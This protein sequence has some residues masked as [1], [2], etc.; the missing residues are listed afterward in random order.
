MADFR[1]PR[2]ASGN[3]SD[4]RRWVKAG[5]DSHRPAGSQRRVRSRHASGDSV[6]SPSHHRRSVDERWVATYRRYVH[7]EYVVIVTDR[8]G[9]GSH[10]YR[11]YWM[12]DVSTGFSPSYPLSWL[13][14]QKSKLVT[15]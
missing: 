10:Q 9:D 12:G 6:D 11:Q 13:P 14:S 2:I 15:Q 8:S 5:N 7:S 4:Q 3:P 1:K